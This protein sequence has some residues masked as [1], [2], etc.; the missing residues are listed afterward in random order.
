MA[1]PLL[2]VTG[3]AGRSEGYPGAIA[4]RVKDVAERRNIEPAR[5]RTNRIRI[6]FQ[7]ALIKL[8][9]KEAIVNRDNTV[10]PTRRGRRARDDDNARAFCFDCG[11]RAP[12]HVHVQVSGQ[13]FAMPFGEQVMFVPDLD[14][15]Y[16]AWI[17]PKYGGEKA[18]I[19]GRVGGRPRYREI[20]AI[21]P[22][23]AR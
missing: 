9:E 2:R 11:V 17:A 15:L 18:S 12:K 1:E 4:G 6:L 16:F 7:A 14:G 3:R 21:G 20:R 13:W 22:G 23:P 10:I 8:F 19:I 5:V